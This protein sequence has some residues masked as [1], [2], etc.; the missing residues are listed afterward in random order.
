MDKKDAMQLVMLP[1]MWIS[2]AFLGG[3]VLARQVTLAFD[4][5]LQ[6]AAA[7]LLITIVVLIFPRVRS[8]LDPDTSSLAHPSIFAKPFSLVPL[9]LLFLFLGAARFQQKQ[10]DS[11]DPY[12][13]I[14]YVDR[15]YEV[16]VTGIIAN[17]PDYRDTYTNLQ[18]D[19]KN[20]NV[21]NRRSPAVTGK[22][23][24]RVDAGEI[25]QY[26]DFIRLR[27]YLK[28]PPENEEFSYRDYL[29]LHGIHAYM[30][31]AE[32]TFLPEARGGLAIMAAIYEL[33][34]SAFANVYRLFPDPE[35]SLL[36]GILL[37]VE[38]GLS[39]DVQQAFKDT[40][41]TH[42][43]AISGFNI[44]IIAGLFISLFG[45]LFG[46]ALGPVAAV[47]GIAAYTLLVGADAAVVRAAIMGGFALLARQL[48]RQQVGV[49]SLVGVAIVMSFL[50]P[51]VLWDVGF[52]LS[53][54]A[55]AGLILY[56][57]P[58]TNWF[59]NLVSR[60][61]DEEKAKKIAGP[62]GEYILFTLAAQFATIPIMAYHFGRISIISFLAN[63]FIL[64]VQ[65]AVMIIGGVALMLS[66][67]YFPLGQLL[68][69][70]ALPF[71]TYTIRMVE[72]FARMPHGVIV[73]GDMKLVIVVITYIAMLTWTFARHRFQKVSA[74][75]T[76]TA[77]IA[78]LFI[79][80]TATWR[81]A[82]A[83][84]DNKLH[85]TFFDVGSAEAVLIETPTG[86]KLLING[87]ERISDLSSALGRRLPPFQRQLDWLIVAS[88]QEED[89]AALPR[90]LER[91]IP[92]NVLWSGNDEASYASRQ[93]DDYLASN[94]IPVTQAE[95]DQHLELGNGIAIRVQAA[96]PR[97]A[98]LLLEWDSFRAL[99]PIGMSFA[100]LE[101]F[102][103]GKAIGDVS[104]LLLADSGYA[105]INPPEW[106]ENLN[107]QL[108]VLSVAADDRFGM[109]PVTTLD[110]LQ[111]Y[112]LLRTDINGW[113]HISTDGQQMWVESQ[114]R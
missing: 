84:P 113:I 107:P 103:N 85:I 46:K 96:G 27:G 89:L 31:N 61:T 75:V 12:D 56:A 32:A 39:S 21:G 111:E 51:M 65:P 76:S 44:T 50:N 9:L 110:S 45:R 22:I 98:V 19:V 36:A 6:L 104:V 26:G 101:S 1:L 74:L 105:P 4:V 23:L 114:R 41:T 5:W 57:E 100:D 90:T 62:V 29:A 87:G 20:I 71:T 37:G 106:I 108:A 95:T 99:L 33:K 80:T 18:L 59:I 8:R 58:L 49:K 28:T 67:L 24:V 68:A 15:E 17:P 94:E 64:P 72:F 13:I 52:Q 102:E 42:I 88:T 40:G 48:G 93:L 82:F 25:Y 97:G 91:F 47:I 2:L 78:T 63:P 55:T 81:A 30:S 69:L 92:Q 83:A 77:I 3:V 14:W 79:F 43:I 60:I 11:N 66:L 86:E 35:A 109:P 112:T 38:S 73:L 53:F 7:S 34:D 16:L 10:P 54:A 70:F